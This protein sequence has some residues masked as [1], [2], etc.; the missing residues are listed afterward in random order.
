MNN[1]FTPLNV[2]LAAVVCG[3]PNDIHYRRNTYDL[4]IAAGL[5][6]LVIA[7][8][9]VNPEKGKTL[10]LTFK[11]PIY[12]PGGAGFF[13]DG[14]SFSFRND[15]RV[16]TEG[17]V[18]TSLSPEAKK[19]HLKTSIYYIADTSPPG[20]EWHLWENTTTIPRDVM[21]QILPNTQ[22][23]DFSIAVLRSI[24]PFIR[25]MKEDR[26]LLP[27]LSFPCA[28]KEGSLALLETGI[29]LDVHGAR[30]QKFNTFTVKGYKP[31]IIGPQKTAVYCAEVKD[32]YTIHIGM[33]FLPKAKHML[34]LERMKR[35]GL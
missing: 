24:N 31:Q 4:Q 28:R 20:Y 35:R 27:E 10:R 32:L 21:H 14:D 6:Q 34:Y 17:T 7:L 1:L 25:A 26:T 11:R 30:T 2:E 19:S 16:L 3:D 9:R 18:C 8:D 29:S 23:T 12:I 33:N 5:Q 22:T 13:S 15:K